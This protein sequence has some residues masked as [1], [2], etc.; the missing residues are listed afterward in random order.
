MDFD[1]YDKYS[2]LSNTELLKILKQPGKYQVAA[3]DTATQILNTREIS[4][5]DILETEEYFQE[6][7]TH[8]KLKKEK[9][10]SYKE[11][12]SDFFQPILQ[13]EADVKPG[14]WL[15]IFFAIIGVQY[16]FSL[17]T[18]IRSIVFFI[19]CQTCRFNVA[20]VFEFISLIYIPIIFYLLYKKKAG[21][22]FVVCR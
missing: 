10:N 11:K 12:A 19:S 6:L 21:L 4:E 2:N 17:Y 5:A 13:P 14:K 22:D 16:L 7:Q 8:E 15:N 1:F 20:I 3:I 9:I 18:T